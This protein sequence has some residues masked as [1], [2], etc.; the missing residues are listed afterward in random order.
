MGTLG[1]EDI[2]YEVKSAVEALASQPNVSRPDAKELRRTAESFGTLTV[3]GNYSF[4]STV[5]NRSAGLTVY[6]GGPEVS[7]PQ[8]NLKQKEILE[9]VPE[10]V[11]DVHR[12]MKK[13]PFV[14]IEKTMGDNDEFTPHC[15]LFVSV[16]RKEMIRLAYMINQTLFEPKEDRDPNLYLVYIPEWQEK[17][18]QILVFPEIGVTYVL[19]S[20][21][22]GEAKKGFLRMAM[23]YAKQRGMLGL[24]AGSK[25]VHVRENGGKIKKY[26]MLIFG[27][28][29]TGKTTHTC[30]NHGLIEDGEGIEILQDDIV[31]LKKD[32]SALGTERGF[33]LK[34][35]GLDPQT[36]PIIYE[37]ATKP[38]AVFENVM[39][40]YGGK[41]NFDDEILTGNGRGI[42]QRSDLACSTESINLPPTEGLDG[43]KI[44]FITRR[45]TI[46]PIVSKLTQEQ[47][48][49]AFMLGESIESSGSDPARTGEPV[50]E[51]GANPFI[52][53]DQAF[54]GNWFYD[55]LRN[56]PNVECYLLNTGGVGEINETI[57]GHRVIKRK[58]LRPEI[59]ETAT[60]IRGI[61]KDN[62]EWKNCSYSNS[63]VATKVE[64][65]NMEKFDPARFY[66]VEKL[67]ALAKKLKE[68]RIE[69]LKRFVG[70]NPAIIDSVK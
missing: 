59:P 33:Y 61:L 36:Q 48:A 3:W 10:T 45:N 38:D 64:G 16:H 41:A 22:Y 14:C 20:D 49:A 42:I 26:G 8:L 55:F 30:H 60:I 69:W 27:L 57:N 4:A 34:T 2:L 15:I 23:W 53:G 44:L 9:K 18:R 21:Y 56:H 50:H 47:A 43:L 68:E 7:Q 51:V 52:I 58:A 25:I 17:D 12:Y 5:K 24:H 39:I 62:I 28:T 40:E 11:E 35:E 63:L 19:G 70:L 37:A 32:G 29:A 31:F 46:V 65:I 66:Y 54:E 6:V 13:A 1:C 67:N